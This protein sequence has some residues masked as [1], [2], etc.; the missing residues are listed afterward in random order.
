[1]VDKAST[2]FFTIVKKLK[3]FLCHC[4][5]YAKQKEHNCQLTNTL[6]CDD[7]LCAGHDIYTTLLPRH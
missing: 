7:C 5:L 6:L 4:N 3:A 2:F 1:M